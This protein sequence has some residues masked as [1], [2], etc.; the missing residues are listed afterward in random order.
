MGL[1]RLLTNPRVMGPDLIGVRQAWKVYRQ[2]FQDSRTVFI[3]EPPD[4]EATW[5][6][7]TD[8]VSSAGSMWADTYLQAFACARDLVVVTFD[9]A[10]SRFV[11]PKPVVL[12]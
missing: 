5:Q 8:E 9:R 6:A 10:F 1:L 11:S 3:I 2:L 7:I 4:V 12:I